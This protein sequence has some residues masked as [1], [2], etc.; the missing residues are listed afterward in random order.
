[1]KIWLTQHARALSGTLA[2]FSRARTTSLLNIAVIGIALAL[3][4]GGYV[5]LE[6]VQ[7]LARAHASVPQL[8]LYLAHDAS[9]EDTAGVRKRLTRHASVLKFSFIP[10]EQALRE[11]TASAGLGD[12]VSSL[13]HNP[14]PDAFVVDAKDGGAGNL[15]KMRAEFQKWPKVAHVQLDSA[16]AKRLDALLAFGEVVVLLVAA[17]LAFG[18]VAVTFNTIRLQIMT[19]R[20]E[21]EVSRLIGATDS[22]IRRPFLYYGT[23]LG[24]LGGFAAWVLVWAG[25]YALNTSLAEVGQIYGVDLSMR[26]LTFMESAAI[27]VLSTVTGWLGAWLSVRQHLAAS[28]PGRERLV[29]HI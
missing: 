12:V 5:V 11:L 24:A 21:I 26:A 20:E 29:Y 7:R 18:M 3:P 10:R 19:R 16:W 22:F 4:A 6:N 25:T 9:A 1:M 2:R 27:L 14:L 15:E 28:E 23:V 17:V 13:R 8:S